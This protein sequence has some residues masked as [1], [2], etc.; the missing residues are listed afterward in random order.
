M[1]GLEVKAGWVKVQIEL[2]LTLTYVNP[3]YVNV[4]INDW[5]KTS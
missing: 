4:G 1:V 5:K 3:T 2:H